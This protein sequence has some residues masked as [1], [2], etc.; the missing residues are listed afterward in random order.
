MLSAPIYHP[1]FW[2]FFLSLW[3]PLSKSVNLKLNICLK[4]AQSSQNPCLHIPPISLLLMKHLQQQHW[5]IFHLKSGFTLS[6]NP[7]QFLSFIFFSFSDYTESG[8]LDYFSSVS[9]SAAA[10]FST[11]AVAVSS[12]VCS[13]SKIMMFLSYLRKDQFYF[14]C[15]LDAGPRANNVYL[16][17]CGK[18]WTGLY[19]PW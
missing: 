10:A 13:Q 15:W 14:K 12:S 18:I 3:L 5:E 8:C 19:F 7:S 2:N 9:F 4:I 17:W 16:R 11:A 1:S 6:S